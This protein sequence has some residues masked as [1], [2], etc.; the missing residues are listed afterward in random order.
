MLL[1]APL[2][3]HKPGH[4]QM[5]ICSAC[6][7]VRWIATATE[8]FAALN[9]PQVDSFCGRCGGARAFRIREVPVF[10][11]PGYKRLPVGMHGFAS[12]GRFE[13]TLCTTC[14]ESHWW[15]RELEDLAP[16]NA[17][18]WGL[19]WLEKRPASGPYR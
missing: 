10:P 9:L 12:V 11:W 19:E 14:G 15:A 6:G 13:L 3:S 7:V 5:L 2:L 8:A 18:K 4:L 1:F 17:A 16:E